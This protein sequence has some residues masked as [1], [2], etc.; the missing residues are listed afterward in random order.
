[1]L[2]APASRRT[3]CKFAAAGADA[4]P[5]KGDVLGSHRVRAWT[6]RL[7][8][9]AAIRPKWAEPPTSQPSAEAC[10]QRAKTR[11]PVEHQVPERDEL[12]RP[13]TD[14]TAQPERNSPPSR[15]P[16]GR[17]RNRP[18]GFSQGR[19]NQRRGDLW[20]VHRHELKKRNQRSTNETFD[21]YVAELERAFAPRD[22]LDPDAVT[23]AELGRRLRITLACRVA[24]EH[25]ETAWRIAQG[26]PQSGPYKLKTIRP[27][28]T[29]SEQV[30]RYYAKQRKANHRQR[31]EEHKPMT[32]TTQATTTRRN[33]I[34]YRQAIEAQVAQTRRQLDQ[35]HGVIH[36]KRTTS[37]L[38]VLIHDL[39]AWRDVPEHKL[40]K[41]LTDRLDTL[42]EERRI[43]TVDTAPGPRGSRLRVVERIESSD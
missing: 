40:R 41:T 43:I 19:V 42:E 23:A 28:D 14:A 3:L 8:A 37:E 20:A 26:W 35:L 17:H 9:A 34:L 1:M 31:N 33:G 27:R 13:E 6:Q 21:A 18:A 2:P 39:P 22:V 10:E 7:I 5:G 25:E 32:A 4:A 30:A 36:G 12:S 24:I 29:S 16:P 38:L 15:R 11:P